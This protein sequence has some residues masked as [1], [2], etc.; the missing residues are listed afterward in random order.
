M[1]DAER[2]PRLADD[3]TLEIAEEATLRSAMDHDFHAR[4]YQAVGQADSAAKSVLGRKLEKDELIS[5]AVAASIA[6]VM[7]ERDPQT[8]ERLD[9]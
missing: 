4:V 9:A 7:A 5:C 3:V 8:G 1:A 2:P 6:L